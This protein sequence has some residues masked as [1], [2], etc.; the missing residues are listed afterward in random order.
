MVNDAKWNVTYY[1]LVK[2]VLIADVHFHANSKLYHSHVFKSILIDY[3][4]LDF[5]PMHTIL[6]HELSSENVSQMC[7]NIV[8]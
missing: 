5:V 7:C 4:E 6:Y 2:L 1:S 8:M 3:N